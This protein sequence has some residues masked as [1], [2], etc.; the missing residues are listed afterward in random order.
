MCAGACEL[1]A[2]P[3]CSVP[4]DPRRGRSAAEAASGPTSGSHSVA[5][6]ASAPA[7]PPRRRATLSPR[8]AA[9]SPGSAACPAVPTRR[10]PLTP[11][12]PDLGG[13]KLPR[14]ALLPRNPL[15][16]RDQSD[17]GFHLGSQSDSGKQNRDVT[18]ATVDQTAAAAAPRDTGR[19]HAWS[20]SPG[21]PEW[22]WREPAG[23]GRVEPEFHRRCRRNQPGE[24]LSAGIRPVMISGNQVK[25][26]GDFS[27]PSQTSTAFRISLP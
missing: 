4:G 11:R 9:V 24:E 14:P 13:R 16:R 5:G 2:F 19:C 22:K 1:T 12:G 3:L 10:P 25:I 15:H 7:Q 21:Q 26:T 17:P 8:A 23:N 18:R 27:V 20:G 6:A